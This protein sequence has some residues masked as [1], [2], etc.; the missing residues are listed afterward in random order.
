[1]QWSPWAWGTADR[2]RAALALQQQIVDADESAFRSGLDRAV[3]EDLA[4]LDRLEATAALDDQ[5]ILLRE[6]VDRETR[7]R[8]DERVASAAEYLDQS[9]DLLDA[10]LSRVT[11]RVELAR[12]GA[13]LL[14]TL[15]LEVR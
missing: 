8:Y 2:E 1:M 3:Q 13:R 14:T 6:A 12:A 5:I 9:T 10:R 15:G 11:G 7:L 4:A